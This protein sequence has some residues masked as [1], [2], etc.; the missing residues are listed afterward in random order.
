MA[1][2]YDPTTDRGKV[3]LLSYDKDST[4]Y[5]FTDA[6]IDAFLE[7]NADSIWL[8]AAD[9]LR[10]KATKAAA[11]GYNI[12]LPGTLKLDK[13]EIPKFFLNLA[14][15]YESRAVSSLD[16]TAEYVDAFDYDVDG[17]GDDGSEYE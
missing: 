14:G 3:R 2:V 1:F 13:K 12:E 17:L 10:V 15:R 8:A 4:S 7:Q 9:A 5:D 11:S 6:D 16:G